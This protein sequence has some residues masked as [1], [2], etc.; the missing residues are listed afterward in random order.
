MMSA[1]SPQSVRQPRRVDRS[2]RLWRTTT[3]KAREVQGE[4]PGGGQ[5]DTRCRR[6][7]A[8]A[9]SLR[10]RADST[11]ARWWGVSPR[12]TDHRAT[13]C[14]QLSVR[15]STLPSTHNWIETNLAIRVAEPAPERSSA[16]VLCTCCPRISSSNDH[17][18]G[19]FGGDLARCEQCEGYGRGALEPYRR[20]RLITILG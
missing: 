5:K 12:G 10:P 20:R 17:P 18:R 11:H 15:C 6:V 8:L 3:S 16:D 1:S 2:A 14:S 13:A 7:T 9:K 19:C 4:H